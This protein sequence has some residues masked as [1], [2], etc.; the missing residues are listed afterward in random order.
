MVGLFTTA[1]ER[2]RN[3][4]L[5]TD[6]QRV[7]VDA[8]PAFLAMLGRRR[9]ALIGQPLYAFVAGGP[10]ATTE[11][12]A[13]ALAAG[14]FSGEAGLMDADG[15]P[16]IVHRRPTR[17]SSPGAGSSSSSPSASRAGG[18]APGAPWTRIRRRSR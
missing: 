11:E 4:M 12:W 2:S 15:R 14:R 10:L 9:D 3:A 7:I 8:N 5:L 16:V 13:S 18:R 6:G 17:R 1:F